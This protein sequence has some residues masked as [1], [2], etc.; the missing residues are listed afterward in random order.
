MFNVYTWVLRLP[1]KTPGNKKEAD[2]YIHLS[3]IQ[4]KYSGYFASSASFTS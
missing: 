1:Y 4:T 3:I 2:I